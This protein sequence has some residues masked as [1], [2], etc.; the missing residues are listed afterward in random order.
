[1]AIGGT[2]VADD[3]VI[4]TSEGARVIARAPDATA[5]LIEA[6]F[7][8]IL[9]AETAPAEITLAV[10]LDKSESRRMPPK[11]HI[12]IL[13]QR[14]PLLHKVESPHFA[15]AIRQYLVSGPKS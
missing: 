11:R 6:R 7:V 9:K 13:G 2:L 4:L 12:A 8:G 5:G 1:M 3:R 14:I 10:D 15:S